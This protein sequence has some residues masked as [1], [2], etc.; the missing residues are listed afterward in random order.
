MGLFLEKGLL[1]IAL[2]ES[3]GQFVA[4]DGIT[5]MLKLLAGSWD[6]QLQVRLTQFIVVDNNF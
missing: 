4:M 2:M 5:L 6:S 1:N 3:G